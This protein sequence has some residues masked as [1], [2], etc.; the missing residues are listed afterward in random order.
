MFR[1]NNFAHIGPISDLDI[2]ILL[3]ATQFFCWYILINIAILKIVFVC[4]FQ[5]HNFGRWFSSANLVTVLTKLSPQLRS[6][7]LPFH[8]HN[9]VFVNFKTANNL[10]I[11]HNNFNYQL[12]HLYFNNTDIFAEPQFNTAKDLY[13]SQNNFNYQLNHRYFKN[14]DIFA[15]PQFRF[16]VENRYF[17][18]LFDSKTKL[19]YVSASAPLR[20]LVP[21]QLLMYPNPHIKDL[22]T[23]GIG[24]ILIQ[25]LSQICLTPRRKTLRI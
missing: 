18:R 2:T 12:N 22:D 21:F 3:Q 20:L 11:S 17:G 5:H 25:F 7:V 19:K 16:H 4:Y 24:N 8:Y 14:S 13:I 9:F 23:Y 15:G 6:F 10:Y 1:H